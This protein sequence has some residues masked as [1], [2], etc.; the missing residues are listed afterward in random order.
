VE[1]RDLRLKAM[2]A[3]MIKDP[4]VKIK[5]ASSYAGIA[6]Y[7]KFFDGETKQL[8]EHDVIAR[9]EKEE[10]AFEKWALDKKEYDNLFAEIKQ[11]YDQW[12][13]YAKSRVY[14][15][16]GVLGSPL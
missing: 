1:L 7:W 5:M 3:E 16:E 4:A 9:K 12:R 11:N 2:H 15:L 6:N 13:P 8:I 10:A 14:L